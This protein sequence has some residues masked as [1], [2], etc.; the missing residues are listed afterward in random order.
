MTGPAAG[1]GAE[2]L[3]E[4]AK[5]EAEQSGS[6]VIGAEHILLRAAADPVADTAFRALGMAP[7]A[8][9]ERLLAGVR[10]GRG[11]AEGEDLVLS[12]HARRLLDSAAAEAQRRG[13]GTVGAEHLLL[14][15]FRD[16]RGTVARMLNDGGVTPGAARNAVLAAMG[17]EPE[18]ETE[19]AGKQPAR[20]EAKAA[21]EPRPPREPKA[22]REPRPPREPRAAREKGRNSDPR[23]ARAE[24]PG[25]PE[26]PSRPVPPPKV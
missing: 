19:P 10:K 12:S 26:P 16:P 23:A 21:A 25:R 1:E 14:A 4:E 3:L 5:A 7:D 22:A 20:A 17:A 15:A 6:D 11:R 2:R 8:A 9:R 24:P 18:P 13:A